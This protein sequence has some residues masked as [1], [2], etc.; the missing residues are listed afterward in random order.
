MA[1]RPTLGTIRFTGNPWPKGHAIEKLAWSGRLD[2]K[3]RG[4]PRAPPEEAR[5]RSLRD[6]SQHAGQPQDPLRARFRVASGVSIAAARTAMAAFVRESTTFDFV[7]RKGKLWAVPS[8]KA[9]S[10]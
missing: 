1:K 3:L 4:R 9:R 8:K 10:T 7:K 6:R 2:P 5:V